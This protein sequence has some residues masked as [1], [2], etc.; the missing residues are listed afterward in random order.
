MGFVDRKSIEAESIAGA[1]LPS[2]TRN[3]YYLDWVP[4]LVHPDRVAIPAAAT[5]LAR[6]VARIGITDAIV[7]L[8]CSSTPAEVDEIPVKVTGSLS[9]GSGAM[10]AV[11][12]SLFPRAPDSVPGSLSRPPLEYRARLPVKK[13]VTL[14][15]ILRSRPWNPAPLGGVRKHHEE[16][17]ETEADQT[18]RGDGRVS[19]PFTDCGWANAVG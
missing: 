16:Q 12:R 9:R 1:G 17:H 13:S 15:R 6:P 2:P 19:L 4:R 5:M 14:A 11:P 10:E 3:R 8:C 18:S 7:P